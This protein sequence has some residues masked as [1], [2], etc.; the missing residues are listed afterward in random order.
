MQPES[1]TTFTSALLRDRYI[2]RVVEVASSPPTAAWPRQSP[3]TMRA[4]LIT[5]PPRTEARSPLRKLSAT[6]KALMALLF[7]WTLIG[8]VSG[9]P[10]LIRLGQGGIAA[11]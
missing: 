6:P 10:A 7:G 4:D 3:S 9:S 8:P 1:M 11:V 2:R 5:T